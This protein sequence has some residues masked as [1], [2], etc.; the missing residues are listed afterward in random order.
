MPR[1]VLFG[2]VTAEGSP[3]R[4]WPD[5]RHECLTFGLVGADVALGPA[6]TWESVAALLPA[7]WRPDA[8]VLDLSRGGVPAGLWS[9]PIPL[10]GL[11]GSWGFRWHLDRL[12]LPRCDL[13]LADPDGA[14]ALLRDGIEQTRAGCPWTWTP[15]P[16]NPEEPE[17]ERDLDVLAVAGLHPAADREQLPWLARLARL[18]ERR[19]VTL[20]K[21][22][23]PAAFR[24]LLARARIFWH[25]GRPGEGGRTALE[26][27]AAGCLVFRP[28]TDRELTA[29]LPDGCSVGYTDADL[30]ALLDHYL[31]R[32]DERC[33]LAQ[34]GRVRARR[35]DATRSW[36][37]IM[38]LL[39]HE[40]SALRRRAAARRPP[41][42]EAALLA[43]TWQ[44]VC[45]PAWVDPALV[46]DLAAA[47]LARPGS[48]LCHNALGVARART[49]RTPARRPGHAL[50]HFHRA[51]ASD[52]GNLLAGL[53]LAEALAGAGQQ[54]EAAARARQTLTV[55]RQSGADGPW[56]RFGIPYPIELTH[57]RAE[58][59]RAAWRHAGDSSGEAQAKHDLLAWR[60]HGLLARLENHLHHRYEATLVRPDLPATRAALG[61]ALAVAGH[62]AEALP[63]L[64]R[65]LAGN[66]FDAAAAHTL[67]EALGALGLVDEQR[68]LARDRRLLARAAPAVVTAEPWFAETGPAAATVPAAPASPATTRMRVSL[69]MIVKDEEH[70]LPACLDA[71]A[72][73]ADEVVVVDTGSSDNT[74]AVAARYGAQVFSFGWCD[75]F[76]AARNASL[77]HATG[78]WVLWLDADDR[79]DEANR[80]KLRS[81]LGRLRDEDAAYLLRQEMPADP[82]SG[83]V[84]IVDQAKLFRL[85]PDVRFEYRV[86][87][88][89]V[90]AVLRRGGLVR[91]TDVV[92]Q[93]L[94]YQDPALRRH[95]LERNGRLLRLQ[96][97][98]RPDDPFTL[99][100]LG[101]ACR[102][103]GRLDE[104]AAL[105]RRSLQLA[106]SGYNLAAKACG[107]L[108]HCLGQLG[109]TEEALAVCRDG[110]VRFAGDAE[111][112]F[113][114]ALL[115]WARGDLAAAEGCFLRLLEMPPGLALAGSDTG[116]HDY[117][118]R[119]HLALLYGRQGRLGEAE[120]QWQAALAERPDWAPAW[121]G[122]GELYLQCG[123]NAE[124]E[125][126]ICRLDSDPATALVAS[127]LRVLRH[128]A[129]REF[130]QARRL[131]ETELVRD[132]YALWLRELLAQTLTLEGA[133]R[134]AAARAWGEVLRL[135]PNHTQARRQLEHPGQ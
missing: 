114:E 4:A 19:R 90:P 67:F 129:R 75:S 76:A 7:D 26:A 73:L 20:C 103:L 2:P 93:H 111:L 42:P 135:E 17:P 69:C 34:E 57:F 123:R 62:V 113:H 44:V 131:L 70:N 125:Q 132:R 3:N 99:F 107:L 23:D 116:L 61:S 124:V 85:R 72:D 108:A 9:A 58:W 109:R 8:L 127:A 102:D 112:V 71:A 35:Q 45:D 118:T 104:A 134:D 110:A 54:S 39:D 13:V 27:A 14:D 1:R 28:A 101:S 46:P 87:E 97:A 24:R 128:A 59:E 78:D 91:A 84:A 95:K 33:A 121:I 51:L 83:T 130:A 98:E 94:G 88:Q 63:H 68:D 117:K 10:V 18:S 11:A 79:L 86:H 115:H 100:Y 74:R 119:R 80:R 106:P 49:E 6:A 64:R 133:E 43:R 29:L 105:Y 22:G 122:L 50:R 92:F 37:D 12:L 36:Q 38:D 120:A 77:D 32:E 89:I 82:V 96:D 52:P 15:A 41:T 47:L 65:A 48:A 16:P 21:E 25:R 66:P 126:L 81:L 55:L 53:N 40:W 60:L 5:S 56:V 31:S 30:E